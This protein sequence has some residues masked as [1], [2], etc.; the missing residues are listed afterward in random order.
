MEKMIG[1]APKNSRS[2]KIVRNL[3]MAS[4]F[5]IFSLLLIIPIVT[6]DA[7]KC[8]GNLQKQYIVY[9]NHWQQVY[10]FER[11]R[12][13]SSLD[14]LGVAARLSKLSEKERARIENYIL[15]TVSSHQAAFNYII[16]KD[17][18]QKS[19]VGG[20]F[21]TKVPKT[22]EVTTQT[23]ACVAESPGV[24]VIA[25]PTNAKTCGSGTEKVSR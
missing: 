17:K 6:N 8:C 11:G 18:Q 14:E 7:R 25:P 10:Y 13:A 22:N 19:C 5:V 9:L 16:P 20:V 4:P 12:F 15:S 2:R 3:L 23:I 21:L 24:G 1:S